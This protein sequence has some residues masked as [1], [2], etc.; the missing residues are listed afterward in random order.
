MTILHFLRPASLLCCCLVLLTSCNTG[1]SE[2]LR[3]AFQNRTGSALPVIAAG[4]DLFRHEGLEIRKLRFSS[5]PECFEALHTGSADIASMGD[6]AAVIALSRNPSL[7]LLA[8]H[9]SGEHR[10]RIMVPGTSRLHGPQDLKGKRIGIKKG[11]STYGAFLKFLDTNAIDPS[12]V[13]IVDLSPPSMGDALISGSLDAFVASEPTPSAAEQ[14]GAR[15]LATLGGLGN[16]YPIVLLT[17]KRMVDER[18]DD[19]RKL[20]R[21]LQ[22]AAVFIETNH[23]SAAAIMARGTGLGRQETSQAMMRHDYQLELNETT[24]QSLQQTAEFLHSQGTIPIEPDIRQRSSAE[25]LPS[26]HVEQRRSR[27][28]SE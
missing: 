27:K 4:Q 12:S 14:R 13:T 9:S 21:A 7:V 23:D 16:T 19:I 18:P 11:T 22:R 8:S 25:F 5:G 17:R 28:D 24:L 6:A 2:T 1:E 20:T 26:G 15:E 3:F 10:H